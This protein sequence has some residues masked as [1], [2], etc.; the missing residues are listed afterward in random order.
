MGIPRL[1]KLV[2]PY[3]KSTVLGCKT[4]GCEEHPDS[5]QVIIDGPS[6][7]YHI[8]YRLLAHK[9]SDLCPMDAVPS[10]KDIGTGI[11][12]FLDELQRHRVLMYYANSQC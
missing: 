6:L 8:Y 1:K 11:L 5:N 3:A 7:A 4:P 10:Y 12:I 2:Q 9:D